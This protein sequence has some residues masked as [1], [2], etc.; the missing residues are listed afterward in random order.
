[1][2]Y[3]RSR[4]WRARGPLLGKLAGSRRR[5]HADNEFWPSGPE[6]E[7]VDVGA[8]VAGGEDDLLIA[9]APAMATDGSPGTGQIVVARIDEA[10]LL[11]A[12]KRSLLTPS[13]EQIDRLAD[14]VIAS[15]LTGQ[16]ADV[17]SRCSA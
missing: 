9:E 7:Q 12:Q 15:E 1:V 8:E 10:G 3:I 2:R 6:S 11:A 4:P 14:A 17:I 5:G 16:N 13:P